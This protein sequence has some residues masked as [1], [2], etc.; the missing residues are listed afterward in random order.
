M[1]NFYVGITGGIGSGKSAASDWFATQQ[2]AVVDADIVA[3]EVVAP[4]EIALAHIVARFGAEMLLDDGYLDRR[5]LREIVFNDAQARLDLEAITHPVIR[6]AIIRQLAAATSRYAVLVSPLLF[7][8]HQNE[9]V[10]RTLLIDAPEALQIER[11]MHRDHQTEQQ[12]RQIIASQLSREAKIARA[13][14]VV[15]NDRDLDSLYQQLLPLHHKYLEL[16][17][18]L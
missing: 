5:A 8:S 7:E 6:S 17:A 10:Q 15:I 3:R 11:A 1:A 12:I 18:K 13:D 16:S 14:D 9:L 2:I 4:G